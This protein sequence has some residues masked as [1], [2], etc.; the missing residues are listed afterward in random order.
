MLECVLIGTGRTAVLLYAGQA[1]LNV[2]HHIMKVKSSMHTC[3]PEPKALLCGYET[4][5]WWSKRRRACYLSSVIA[6][7]MRLKWYLSV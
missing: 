1:S 7:R 4:I 3:L 2:Y 6:R 5:L